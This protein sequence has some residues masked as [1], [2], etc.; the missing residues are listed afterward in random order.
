MAHAM[1]T[2]VILLNFHEYK[3]NSAQDIDVSHKFTKEYGSYSSINICRYANR[4]FP[5]LRTVNL[6]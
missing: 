2:L 5:F 4:F 6:H 1:F 3:C